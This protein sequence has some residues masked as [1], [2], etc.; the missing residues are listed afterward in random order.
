M[1]SAMAAE[2]REPVVQAW[3]EKEEVAGEDLDIKL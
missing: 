1:S 2:V 3:R